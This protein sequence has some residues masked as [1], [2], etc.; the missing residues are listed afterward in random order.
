[1]TT[2]LRTQCDCNIKQQP[3]KISISHSVIYQHASSRAPLACWQGMAWEPHWDWAVAG[4]LNFD[5]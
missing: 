4:L 2:M 1:N 5:R 3:G